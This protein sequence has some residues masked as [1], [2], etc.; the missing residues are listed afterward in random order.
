MSD[1][2]EANALT[3]QDRIACMTDDE[4][5]RTYLAC[6]GDCTDVWEEALASACAE[7]GIDI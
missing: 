1:P 4:L 2:H 5:R 7:R 3:Y 6:A